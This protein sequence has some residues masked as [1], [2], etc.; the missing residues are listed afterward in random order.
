MAAVSW[1]DWKAFLNHHFVIPPTFKINS[2]CV[3]EA[4]RDETGMLFAKKLSGTPTRTAFRVISDNSSAAIVVQ[5]TPALYSDRNKLEITQLSEMKAM[6]K[7]NGMSIWW[8]ICATDITMVT[9]STKTDT[10]LTERIGSCNNL[11]SS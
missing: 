10:S 11:S 7:G 1:R 2:Y 6:N 9:M 3:Y 8:T 4:R 5:C